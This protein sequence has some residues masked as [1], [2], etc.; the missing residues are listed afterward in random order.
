[1]SGSS[2]RSSSTLMGGCNTVEGPE[3]SIGEGLRRGPQKADNRL[4]IL[5]FKALMRYGR[6]YVNRGLS[7][8]LIM[9]V[10]NGKSILGTCLIISIRTLA[11]V[12]TICFS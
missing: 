1:M 7:L 12:K 2:K 9:V 6:D 11:P 8:S 3:Q 4:M 5:A 10:L